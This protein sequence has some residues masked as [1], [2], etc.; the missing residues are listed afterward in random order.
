MTSSS[1]VDC[2]FIKGQMPCN[3]AQI[4]TQGLSAECQK[5][6]NTRE[7]LL[8]PNILNYNTRSLVY[9]P[10]IAYIHTHTHTHAHTHTH[11]NKHMHKYIFIPFIP[12]ISIAL[13]Q[14]HCYAEALPITAIDTVSEFTRRSATDK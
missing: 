4:Q 6:A 12:D 8:S 9:M 14:V 1:A 11:T 5:K 3:P 7:C 2:I 10:S 13:L